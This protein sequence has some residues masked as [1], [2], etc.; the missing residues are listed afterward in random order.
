MQGR[1]RSKRGKPMRTSVLGIIAFVVVSAGAGSGA[2]AAAQRIQFLPGQTIFA[3]PGKTGPKQPGAVC[4]G[5]V[6]VGGGAPSSGYTFTVKTGTTLPKGVF[7]TSTTGVITMQAKNSALPAAGVSKVIHITASDGSKGAN[8]T[9]TFMVQNTG[10]CG[11]AVFAVIYGPLPPAKAHQ[12]YGATLA[13][14]GPPSNQVLRP[15]YT[16]KVH[17]GDHIPPGMVLDQST[18]VLRGTPTGAASGNIYNF[19]VDVKETHTGQKALS[20]S[21]YT[22]LVN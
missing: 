20:F 12:P 15:N 18:G 2:H 17:T 1:F 4:T 10:V 13:I 21:T 11:C 3:C 19:A 6:L 7:L 14:T 22:L 9:V 16:W 8:G 5:N